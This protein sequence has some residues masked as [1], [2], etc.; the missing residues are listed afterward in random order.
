MCG[1]VG[2]FKKQGRANKRER[3]DVVGM[4]ASLV[5]RGP[6]SAGTWCQG[7]LALGHQRL[8]ILDV[9]EN[10][11]QPMVTPDGQGVL[12]L[13]GEIYN[14]QSLRT[15]LESEGLA[16]RST[17]DTEVLLNALHHWGVPNTI[18]RL[19]GMFAFAYFDRRTDALWLS[20]DRLGIKPMSVMDLPDQVLFASEDKALLASGRGS[21]RVA[22]SKLFARHM[23]MT[24]DS[25][26]SYFEGVTRLP[27]GSVWKIKGSVVEKSTYWSP[28]DALDVD[29]LLDPPAPDA[30]HYD[31]LETILRSSLKLHCVS[32]VPLST[33]CS[34]GVDSSLLTAFTRDHRSSFKA[35][36]V[37]PA[38]GD[39][40]REAAERVGRHLGI[41][42]TPIDLTRDT[43]LDL[44]PRAIWHLEGL[45]RMPMLPGLLTMTDR[46]AADGAKVLVTGE[47]ADEQFGGYPW[48]MRNARRARDLDWPRSFFRSHKRQAEKERVFA[49]DLIARADNETAE[50]LFGLERRQLRDSIW[51]KLEPLPSFVDRAFIFT[52][53]ADYGHHMQNL[54]H[55]KD[56][57]SMASSV[58][59]RVPFLE[60]DVIDFAL[61]QP[62]RMRFR[63]QTGKWALKQVAARH[64][65][66]K[67]VFAEKRGFPISHDFHAGTEA[68]IADGPL[69]D[70]MEW[71]DQECAIRM[72]RATFFP[73][74]RFQLLCSDIF[75]RLFVANQTPDQVAGRLRAYA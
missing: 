23:G 12:A 31:Q 46:V 1:L 35:Y 55:Q 39:S 65:P 57:M 18:P 75:L 7:P 41:D 40:E 60:N 16:F 19:N 20:R 73:L 49:R 30:N 17:S 13:N 32:D 50:G 28:L 67:N 63:K 4:M 36:V 59:L 42:V 27:P 45:P 52:S 69:R 10:G 21:N 74:F 70:L 9:S 43:Y 11:H 6:D 26:T 24:D 8:A 34:G 71:S 33:A 47:S 56:R 44:L 72:E 25:K 3:A 62:P 58:E 37:D 66:H 68:L 29:R 64:L 22:S 2:I 38:L 51:G 5:H 48:Q 53:I 61:H 15:E 14:F 54:L